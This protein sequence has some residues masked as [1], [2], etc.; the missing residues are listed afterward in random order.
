MSGIIFF[1][2]RDLAGITQFYRSNLKMSLWLDQGGCRVLQSGNQLLGFCQRDQAETQG[3]IT[4]FYP[5]RAAVDSL[6]E[7]LKDCASGSPQFNPTYN[8]YHFYGR[9]PEGRSFEIQ[10]FEHALEPHQLASGALMHR[11][12]VRS[13]LPDPV[14]AA[15]LDKVFE[16]CRWSPTACNMQAYYYVVIEDKA[17][18]RQVAE[19]RGSSGDPLTAA[20]LAIAVCANAELSRRPIQDACIAA[21]H[22][23]LAAHVYGLGSCWITGVDNDQSKALLG[24]PPQDY[25]ACLT[26][27]GWPAEQIPLPSRREASSLVRYIRA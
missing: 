10:H 19:L 9:D 14:P 6:Y 4:F 11:R 12:S 2:T 18:I 15:L 8:I 13:F 7:S 27:L 24:V 20:P 21:Y 23:L 5:S 3:T 25:I 16:L 17:I 26:P 22:L 1:A